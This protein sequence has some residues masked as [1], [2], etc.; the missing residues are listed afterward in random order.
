MSCSRRSI[1]GFRFSSRLT[2][3][4]SGRLS[5][6]DDDYPRA[7]SLLSYAFTHCHRDAQ[8]NRR[9]ILQYLVPVR[10]RLPALLAGRPQCVE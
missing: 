4:T 10:L 8:A 1:L 6:F 9:R 3:R 7:E 2:P 5:V